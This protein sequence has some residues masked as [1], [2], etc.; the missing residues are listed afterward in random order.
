MYEPSLSLIVPVYNGRKYIQHTLESLEALEGVL[1][2]EFIFQNA[3][4][5]DGTTEIL[6]DFCSGHPNRFH[7]NERDDGQSH[8]INTGM[9]R[10]RGRW[11]TWLCADDLILPN[12]ARA[13]DEAEK[14][15]ADLVYGDVIFIN[16]DRSSPAEGTESYQP[17]SLAKRRLIIQQP[18]TCVLR[19]TWN[20][21][22][23]VRQNLNWAMDYDL[24]LRME[25]AGRQFLRV[26]DFLAIIRVHS[27]AK[28]SSGSIKRMVELWSIIFQSHKRR[29][30]YIRLRPYVVYGLEFIIKFF[31]SHRRKDAARPVKAFLALLHRFFWMI[32]GPKEKHDI[33]QRFSSLPPEIDLLVAGLTNNKSL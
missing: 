3:N 32:A 10:A 29:P 31:E 23:G 14:Q 25:S 1:S 6:N 30:V 17:G 2:C 22:Q 33:Q 13:I 9:A 18:G 28:T 16:G 20:E 27:E 8:A 21:F 7:H 24:F 26:R 15:G 19:K 12:V 4:S 5:S 11:V